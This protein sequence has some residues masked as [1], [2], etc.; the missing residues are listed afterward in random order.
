MSGRPDCLTSGV[1]RDGI[2]E[3][4]YA[5]NMNMLFIKL[6]WNSIWKQYSMYCTGYGT[7]VWLHLQSIL[8]IQVGVQI[9]NH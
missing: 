7:E 1:R 4:E 6:I 3:H 9:S 8:D 2:Y 5:Y